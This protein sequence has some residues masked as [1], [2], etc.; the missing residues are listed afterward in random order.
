VDHAF[1]AVVLS[2]ELKLKP[3]VIRTETLFD[4]IGEFLG[5]DDIDFELAEFS[6]AFHVSAPDRRWAFDVLHQGAMEFLL[7]SPRFTLEFREGRVLAWREETFN[8]R[9]FDEALQVANGLV[10]ILPA[11]VV[12]ELTD[13]V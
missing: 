9:D 11:S 2:T 4:R 1:S 8:V 10:D 5:L 3:L 6:S 12:R 7:Q 13:S